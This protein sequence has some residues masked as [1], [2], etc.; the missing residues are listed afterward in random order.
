[1]KGSRAEYSVTSRRRVLPESDEEDTT[2]AVENW[3]K[4][5]AR[6][7]TIDT[8]ASSTSRSGK[9]TRFSE[10]DDSL[11]FPSKDLILTPEFDEWIHN[12]PPID[13][14]STELEPDGRE[15]MERDA[16]NEE[17]DEEEDFED[18]DAGVHD[19][20]DF[21]GAGSRMDKSARVCVSFNIQS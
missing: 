6:H 12:S 14:E 19:L 4:S 21:V 18:A 3:V 8:Q 17:G 13:L 20:T 11:L 16:G 10:V 15:T 1:M 5:T 7:I 2:A 9:K